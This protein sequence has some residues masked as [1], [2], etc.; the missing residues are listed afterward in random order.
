VKAALIEVAPRQADPRV[1]VVVPPARYG[2]TRSWRRLVTG[3]DPTRAGAYALEGVKLVPGATYLAP[4]GALAVT[5]DVL[6]ATGRDEW[7]ISL[8]AV[9]PEGWEERKAWVQRQ[10]LGPRIV[11]YIAARL[12]AGGGAVDR[13]DRPANQRPGPCERC[14]QTVPVGAGSLRW[15][16][17]GRTAILTHIG[18][19]PPAPPLR[20][21][22]DAACHLCGGWIPPDAGHLLQT[23]ESIL[24]APRWVVEHPD[25]CPA[26]PVP[27]PN[28]DADWCATCGRWVYARAGHWTGGAVRCG[29]PCQASDVPT[30]RIR[31]GDGIAAGDTVRA[32]RVA[33]R[34]GEQ[35]VPVDAPG[36]RV[37]D[38]TGMVS[39]VITVT[40]VRTVDG[41]RWGR[42]RVA[43]WDE[44]A[45]VLA[46][47]MD[48]VTDAQPTDETFMAPF[49][50]E[51]IGQSAL[52]LGLRAQGRSPWLA[53]IV[54]HSRRY[55]LDRRF[56][57]PAVDWT[58]ANTRGTRGVVHHWALRPNAVYEAYYPTSWTKARRVFLRVVDGGTEEITR[59]QVEA[60]LTHAAEWVGVTGDGVD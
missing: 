11:K 58:E 21:S 13:V 40:E 3:I 56:L 23:A 49:M 20:N 14:R 26:D 51:R 54:G 2:A 48:L 1:Q 52:R 9:G 29:T 35:P 32:R 6:P 16:P 25:G 22:Y 46:G 15:P 4:A 17:G 42:V 57:R 43:T 33:P 37:L 41:R 28:R 12:P 18:P 27:P 7:R 36:Y 50:A 10:P 47:E 5:C 30:W 60:W 39:A 55:G 53:E 59:D 38:D 19:C 31:L 24:D 34:P 8:L 45:P 44:A